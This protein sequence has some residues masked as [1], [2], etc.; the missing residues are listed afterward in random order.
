MALRRSRILLV[1]LAAASALAVQDN[2]YTLVARPKALDLNS[3]T[4]QGVQPKNVWFDYD[5]AVLQQMYVL[6]LIRNTT[7]QCTT[8][9]PGDPFATRLRPCKPDEKPVFPGKND[10]IIFHVLNWSSSPGSGLAVSKQNWYVYESDPGWDHTAFAGTRIF[11]KKSVYLFTIHLNVPSDVRYEERYAVDEKHKTPAFLDHFVGV[12]QLFL[13]APGGQ[14]AATSPDLWYAFQ[15]NVKYVP[16]DLQITPT[17]VPYTVPAVAPAAQP[18]T[19]PSAPPTTAN[20][21]LG[22]PPETAPV[23]GTPQPAQPPAAP[24]VATPT[25][26]PAASSAKPAPAGTTPVTLDAKTF[27]NEGKYHID[28][29]V[30]VP[31]TKISELTFTQA[32]N[33][34]VP[35]KVDKQK[36]FALFNYYPV[37]VDL[38]NT[39][40]P[41][42]PYLL[43]GVAI[44]SQPLKKALFGIGWGPIYT[45]FYA[46]L[47]INTK[48]VPSSFECGDNTPG[49]APAGTKLENRTCPEFSF[50]LNVGVGAI[51]DALKNKTSGKK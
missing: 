33:T 40:L 11:G 10:Y 34:I 30:G 13:P 20:G 47:L 49:P 22:P 51:T 46:G 23:P 18:V 3:S 1:I 21:S 39:I 41:K 14:G 15:L 2:Q 19:P 37:A 12:A 16:S 31:I 32:S 38:K 35:A 28:F 27:D 5:N 42:Y 24:P 29:S 43:T 17:M 6:D 36:L 25:P 9:T 4:S 45:N 44:G 50:G 48:R 7:G 8:E 26:I